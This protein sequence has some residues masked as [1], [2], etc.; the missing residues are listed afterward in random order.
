MKC[1]YC[2]SFCNYENS[3]CYQCANEQFYDFSLI[4]W[5]RIKIENFIKKL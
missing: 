3:N 1:H 2:K 4:K 5:L